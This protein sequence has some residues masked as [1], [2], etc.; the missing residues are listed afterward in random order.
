MNLL[1]PLI[2]ISMVAA[3]GLPAADNLTGFPFQNETLRYNVN[4]PSG[5]SLGEAI[6]SA[7]KVT[8]GK[9]TA[10][11]PGAAWNFAL[12]LTVSIPGFPLGDTYRSSAAATDLC[13]TELNREV[14]HGSKKVTEKTT[15]DQKNGTAKRQ[16]V[17]PAGGGSSDLSFHGCGQ[18][19]LAFWFFAR[20]ELGQG[21]VPPP[22]TVFF[23]SGYTV[24]LEYTGAQTIPVAEKP[25]VTDHLVAHVKGPASDFTFEIFY[26]RDAARTPL[27]LK[28]PVTVGTISLELVR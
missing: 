7:S 2:L 27:L 5:L 4:W 11:K 15:F 16:T 20:R 19:G 8:A 26:A 10:S 25:T 6:V 24:R 9:D 22:E 3:P 23:G 13:S 12:N 17:T 21:R 14:S 18:D 28:V 1:R